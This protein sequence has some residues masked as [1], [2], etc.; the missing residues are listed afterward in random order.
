MEIY[1]K[2]DVIFKGSLE[3]RSR[4]ISQLVPGKLT[5]GEAGVGGGRGTVK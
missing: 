3:E 1:S 2:V 5:N 4:E